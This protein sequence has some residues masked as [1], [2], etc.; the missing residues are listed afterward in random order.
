MDETLVE[1]IRQRLETTQR[2]IEAALK[3]SGRTPGSVKLVVV[4]KAQSIET[5]HAAALA[6]AEILGENYAEEAV[7]KINQLSMYPLQWH[8]I[9]HVQSRKARIVAE[10][11][12]MLHSLDSR[13]LAEKINNALSG[14]E[15]VLLVLL[16]L[17]V[18]GEESKSGWDVSNTEAMEILF[19]DIEY[20]QMCEHL[21]INGVMAMPP[22]GE[23]PEESRP[24]F[25]RV[26]DILKA[27]KNRFPDIAWNEVSMG[28]SLDY[29][30]A[31]E[32]GA[33]MVR[34]GQAILG[35][36]KPR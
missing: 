19:S 9:G 5:V 32:E 30:V 36:R 25:K 35:S 4:S 10:N 13:R 29:C 27:L 2:E 24:F 3:R 6:G 33:T 20:I 34:V 26:M 28:T 31:I 21:R 14:T 15:K 23:H 1:T 22:I 18:G 8:M 11:F 12:D 16:E 17:N 7:E